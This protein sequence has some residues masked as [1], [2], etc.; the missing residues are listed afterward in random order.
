MDVVKLDGIEVTTELPQERPK[1]PSLKRPRKAQLGVAGKRPK[2]PINPSLS[3]MQQMEQGPTCSTVCSATS[4][5]EDQ[6]SAS[7][8]TVASLKIEI[9]RVLGSIGLT[10]MKVLP[11]LR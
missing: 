4:T 3:K 9:R 5:A 8:W 6:S 1:A 7:I 2:P 10:L 11:L